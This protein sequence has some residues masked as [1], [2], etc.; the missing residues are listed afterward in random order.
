M[1]H[2]WFHATLTKHG[3]ESSKQGF[4]LLNP[5][6]SVEKHQNTIFPAQKKHTK[7]MHYY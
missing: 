2:A 6:L 5:K 3:V 7:H 4:H 1:D